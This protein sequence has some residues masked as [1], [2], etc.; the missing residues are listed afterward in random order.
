MW[1]KSLRGDKSS[2]KKG[3]TMGAE[4]IFQIQT[5]RWNNSQRNNGPP[6]TKNQK[7][8]GCFMWLPEYWDLPRWSGALP[9]FQ[10]TT[11]PEGFYLTIIIDTFLSQ[12]FSLYPHQVS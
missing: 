12:N 6:I 11:S 9:D 2:T 5:F 1:E 10:L 4:G 8:Y 7:N 3:G